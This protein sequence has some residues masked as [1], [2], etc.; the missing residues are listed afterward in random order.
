MSPGPIR[1]LI[2][3]DS[4]VTR[5]LLA[6]LIEQDPS[7]QVAGAV[8]RGDQ[9]VA[10]VQATPPDVVLMDIHMDGMDGFEATR[11]IMESRPVPIVMCSAVT[12]VHAVA[13]AFRVYEAGAVALVEKPVGG[14]HP[15]HARLAKELL[16]TLRLMSEVKV[17]RRWARRPVSKAPPQPPT[18]PHG[19]EFVAVGASTGGPPALQTL[20][21]GLDK[22]FPVP[23]VV[24]QHI[25][26]GFLPGLSEWLGQTTALQVQI[27]A[28]GIEARPGHVYLAPDDVHLAV[29]EKRR[30]RLERGVPEHGV[31]PSV[32]HLFH[33]V[34]RCCGRHSVGILLTGMGRDGARGLQAMHE[35]G[36]TTLVQD[37]AS[38]VVYGMPGEAVALGAASQ[39]LPLDRIAD[40]L[41]RVVQPHSGSGATP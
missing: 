39:V 25:S 23:I 3:D 15:D 12:D 29:G 17:V 9:A 38:S 18:P 16:Q 10:F 41:L 36:A 34:A 4:Q 24:V 31:R 30:L 35:L 5:M 6:H 21:G 19:I 13:T 22:D 14:E 27:A 40:A 33:S 1:V 2:V 8:G 11:N 28:H 7:L 26:A 20:L 32:D 37:K